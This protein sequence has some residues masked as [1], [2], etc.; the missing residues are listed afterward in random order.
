MP[1]KHSP[2]AFYL[3]MRLHQLVAEC[4]EEAVIPMGV[5][6]TQYT[7]LSVVRRR[8]PVT[9]AELARDLRVSAQSM[10]ESVKVLEGKLLLTRY[11]IEE[12][13]RVLVLKLTAKGQRMLT[14]ADTLIADV[15]DRFFAAL[16]PA[17][18]GHLETAIVKVRNAAIAK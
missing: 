14:R 1:A 3:V 18:R 12:N 17:E 4:L 6:A 5:T 9:S 2:R 16:S 7:V 15:E 11:T 13:K 8:T 10:G